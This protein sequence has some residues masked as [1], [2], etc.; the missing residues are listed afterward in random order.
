MERTTTRIVAAFAVVYV[1]WGST[2]L[3]IRFALETLPGFAMAGVRFLVAGAIVYAWARARGVPRP[4]AVEW[5]SA[6][7]VGALLLLGGNGAVVWAERTVASG[8]AALLIATM[9]LWVVLLEWARPG[10]SRPGLVVLGGLFFGFIG[11]AVLIDPVGALASGSLDPRGALVLVAGSLSWSIGSTLAPRLGLPRSLLLATAMEMIAG[12]VL[13][14]GLAAVTGELAQVDLA[15][16]SMRSIVSFVY[17]VVFGSILAF[18]AFVYLLQVQP[19]ARV[20][21][22]AYV[23]PVVAVFLGWLLAGEPVDARVVTA[24]AIIVAAV[25]MVT[26]GRSTPRDLPVVENIDAAA[27]P[28]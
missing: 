8:P 10:G 17:L 20:A 15:A 5:R 23:N 11:L 12:G 27:S 1:V 21:T 28:G 14:L 25:A 7:I 13:L 9:P 26:L 2:Y 6:A 3:A 22:Y 18:N 24:T 19:P 4:T 16:A